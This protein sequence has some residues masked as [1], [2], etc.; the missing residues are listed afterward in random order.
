MNDVR[1]KCEFIKYALKIAR[2][3]KSI[4]ML[5]FVQTTFIYIDLNLKFQRDIIKSFEF[6][7]INMYLQ[8]L[9]NNKKF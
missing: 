8:K 9:K 5:I 7:T 1:K 2:V 3:S 4:N 6:I